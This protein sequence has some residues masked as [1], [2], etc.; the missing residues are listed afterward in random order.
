[1]L[2]K[3]RQDIERAPTRVEGGGSEAVKGV[4][5]LDIFC[6]RMWIRGV[7]EKED[8]RSLPGLW[9]EEH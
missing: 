4:Q 7:K 2:Q 5:V 3:Y 6:N 9:P 1:M 8:G